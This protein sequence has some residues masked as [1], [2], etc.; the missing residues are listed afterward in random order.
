MKSKFYEPRMFHER[1][2]ATSFRG[3]GHLCGA[4][5]DIAEARERCQEPARCQYDVAL[6]L[7]EPSFQE[8]EELDI[9]PSWMNQHHE[10]EKV[11]VCYPGAQFWA[12]RSRRDGRIYL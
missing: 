8:V 12:W 7:A 1:C 5:A 4:D 3:L 2:N 11:L 9:L 10:F 6:A